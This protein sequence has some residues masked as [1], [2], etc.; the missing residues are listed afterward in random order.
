MTNS[1][2]QPLAG[3]RVLD[4]GRFVAAPFLTQM[5]GDLGAEIIKIERPGTGDDIRGY[6]PPFLKA[7]DGSD[8]TSF[9]YIA[10]NRNKKSVTVDISRPAGADLVRR[11]AARSDIFVENFRAGHLRKY[12]LGYD[13]LHKVN[14]GLVYCSI[15]GFGQTGPYADRPALDTIF[16]ARSGLMSVTGEPDGPPTKVG[17]M[18]CDITAGL[19]SAIGILAA[20]R[21]REVNGGTGQHL[22]MSALE[23]AMAALGVRGQSYLCTGEPP[24]RTGA[25]TPGN[26]PSGLFMCQD[27]YI[28]ITAGADAQFQTLAR[29][30]GADDLASDPRFLRRA[31]RVE[32]QVELI[33]RIEAIL[34]ARPRAHWLDL[35]LD[36]GLMCAPINDVGE[37]FNDPHIKARGMVVEVEHSRAGTVPLVANPIRFSETP[38]PP[39]KAP[40]MLGQHTDEV[41]AQVL[42]ASPEELEGLRA[43]GAI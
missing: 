4:M 14:P 12:G 5:L 1:A 10:N 32:H 30:L 28:V 36:A 41:L 29:T 42:G 22:D 16:Q 21:H 23:V 25:T 9:D 40:P 37:A 39:F 27:D 24:R 43:A 7:R 26:S 2:R 18:N 20:L 11:L 38:I 17:T 6:G 19:Y 15:S 3:V 8:E 35:L 31:S 33:A 34:K 13:D